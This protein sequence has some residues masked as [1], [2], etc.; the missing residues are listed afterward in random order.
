MGCPVG[1]GPEIILKYHAGEI[2]T[3][4]PPVVIGDAAVLAA[5]ADQLGLQIPLVDWQ[6]GS[7]TRPGVVNLLSASDL[8]PSALRAGEPT[9]ETGRA[10]AAYIDTAISLC[11]GNQLDALTTGP[12]SKAALNLAGYRFPGH[13]EMLAER[14]GAT[15]VAMMLTGSRLRVVLV[16]IHCA[17]A[18]VVRSLTTRSIIDLIILTDRALR[19]DFRIKTPRIAVAGLNPHAGESAMFGREE[20]DIIAPAV[21]HCAA[22]GI[23]ADGPHPPDT[24]FHRAASGRFD[25]V[26]CMY[27]DQGLI[28]FKMLHFDDGVNVTLGLPI[29]RTSVDHGTAYDIAGRGIAS[30]QS[31]KQAVA[32]AAQ[33]A[34][35]RRR[36][37]DSPATSGSAGRSS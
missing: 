24:V 13:T 37:D 27:H 36:N 4:V 15:Q 20:I 26:V 31:L 11:T 22:L 9:R 28:P 19:V 21:H 25:A 6:L 7:L 14:T 3:A 35:N 5:T 29:V 16:T 12:I 10:M 34:A 2:D 30:H 33:L 32:L 8:D 17:F 23:T 1:I 18:E